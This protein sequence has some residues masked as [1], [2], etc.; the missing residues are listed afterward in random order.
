MPLGRKKILR[1]TSILH[2]L[3]ENYLPLGGGHDIYNFLSP[4]STDATN[5]TKLRLVVLEKMLT[6]DG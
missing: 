2:L 5:Q 1:N 6:H 4:Y 3:P